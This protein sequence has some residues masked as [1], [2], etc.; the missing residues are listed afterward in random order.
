[1]IE[2]VFV[3]PFHPGKRLEQKPTTLEPDPKRA[4]FCFLLFYFTDSNPDL[5]PVAFVW[6]FRGYSVFPSHRVRETWDLCV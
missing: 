1:L 3:P 5:D 6:R 4:S 2:R